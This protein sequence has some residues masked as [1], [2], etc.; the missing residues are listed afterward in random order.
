MD[1]KL[2]EFNVNATIEELLLYTEA[3]LN[4]P[5]TTAVRE[6]YDL[7]SIT[8]DKQRRTEC[9]R[10]ARNIR[11]AIEIGTAIAGEAIDENT[12]TINDIKRRIAN[13]LPADSGGR[14]ENHLTIC[15]KKESPKKKKK[16]S[17]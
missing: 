17:I 12:E 2:Y 11:S 14:R 13:I 10:L 3:R 7:A 4:T 16:T 8:Y 6:N 5:R 9:S 1:H 15:A